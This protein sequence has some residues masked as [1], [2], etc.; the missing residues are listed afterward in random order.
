MEEKKKQL[1]SL[2]NWIGF[3]HKLQTGISQIQV[4]QFNT[5][6][7]LCNH[8]IEWQI[9]HVHK[10]EHIHIH[11]LFTEYYLRNYIIIIMYSL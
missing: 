4:R 2:E 1:K 10:Y 7:N 8:K 6:N 11:K 9:P 5:K 3:V